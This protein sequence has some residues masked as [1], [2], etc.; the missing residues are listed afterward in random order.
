MFSC[1]TILESFELIFHIYILAN[2]WVCMS[3]FNIVD[4][5]LREIEAMR[6]WNQKIIK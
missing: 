6:N 3:G 2:L 4:R 5:K 1:E